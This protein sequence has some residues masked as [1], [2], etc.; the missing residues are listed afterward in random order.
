VHPIHAWTNLIL[1][2]IAFGLAVAAPTLGAHRHGLYMEP[3][4]PDRGDTAA[5]SHRG[6]RHALPI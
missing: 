5:M 4:R 6:L 3:G 1:A 2:L